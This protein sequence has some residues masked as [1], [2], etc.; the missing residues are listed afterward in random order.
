MPKSQ[1]N[2]L[3]KLLSVN[4]DN[5][6]LTIKAILKIFAAIGYTNLWADTFNSLKD[7]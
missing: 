3:D 6:N 1:D 5:R 2:D 4:V 7:L